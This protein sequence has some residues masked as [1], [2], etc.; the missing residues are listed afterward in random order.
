MAHYLPTGLAPGERRPLLVYLHGLGGSGRR[1]FGR[2][3]L[4]DF[5]RSERVFVVAPDGAKDSVGRRFWNAHPAC[6]DFDGSGRD[7]VARLGSVIASLASWA[8]VDPDRVFVIGFSNGGFMAHAL[9]CR[10]GSR[11]SG[12]AS[13]AGA[14]VAEEE[15]CQEEGT[16]RVLEIHGDADSIVRYQGGSVFDRP[17]PTHDSAPQT[18]RRWGR[19]LG[20]VGSPVPGPA[21][22]LDPTL[23]GAETTVL[24]LTACRRGAVVLWTVRGGGHGLAGLPGLLRKAWTYLTEPDTR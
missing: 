14:G 12:V 2:L 3:R 6:C 1:G 17:G 9:A 22:D 19:L 24:G 15:P 16:L 13:I 10:L 7:D 18:M 8:H 21:F 5:G 23:P 11:L 20:C 4:A